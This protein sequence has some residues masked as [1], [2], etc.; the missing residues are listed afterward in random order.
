MLFPHSYHQKKLAIEF[1]EG[2]TALSDLDLGD[3]VDE[4]HRLNVNSCDEVIFDL[5][6]INYLN[7]SDLGV[8]IKIKDMLL[9]DHINLILLNPSDNI[10]EL[11]N[12]VG[13]NDFFGISEG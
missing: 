10:K 6:K 5:E 13:L 1:I 3:F 8:L 12:I 7:S 11:L 4:I 2:E 9:D